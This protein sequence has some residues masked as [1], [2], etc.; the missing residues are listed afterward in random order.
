[1][2]LSVRGKKEV[3]SITSEE[4]GDIIN[5]VTC[6]NACVT[7]VPPLIALPKKY[8]REVHGRSIDRV[9]FG[10]TSKLLDRD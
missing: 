9:H 5:I 10:L 3:A 4:R 7:Y 6:T 1:M 2:K 8:E